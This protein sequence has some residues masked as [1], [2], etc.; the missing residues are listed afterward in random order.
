[1]IDI[2]FLDVLLDLMYVFLLF[3][4]SVFGQNLIIFGEHLSSSEH[5]DDRK[6]DIVI[7]GKG[8]MQRSDD[9]ILLAEAD[10]SISFSEQ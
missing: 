8:S 1:M 4:G 7:L 6:K 10:Y 5:V 3:K 9:T 2:S